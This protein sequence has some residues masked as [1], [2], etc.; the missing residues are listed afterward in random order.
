MN[1]S[2]RKQIMEMIANDLN[3]GKKIW[4]AYYGWAF[5]KT[6]NRYAAEDL[7]SDLFVRLIEKAHTYNY[8]IDP[9]KGIKD[10]NLKAWVNGIFKN[11]IIEY[12]KEKNK[13]ISIYAITKKK[14]RDDSFIEFPD[15]SA[16]PPYKNVE[17]LERVSIVRGAI[18]Q[19]PNDKKKII[20][21]YYFQNNTY[22]QIAKQFNIKRSTLGMRLRKAKKILRSNRILREVVK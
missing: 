2:K 11:M 3:D 17:N 5:S 8:E 1:S 21:L 18:E 12:Y 15:K 14:N 22:N 9:S 13:T 6:R 16:T 20:Y 4:N 10:K 7:V 19:L